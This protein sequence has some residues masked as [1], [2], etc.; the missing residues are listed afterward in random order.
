MKDRGQ[1][2]TREPLRIFASQHQSKQRE[3]VHKSEQGLN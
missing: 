1:K 2:L 3:M